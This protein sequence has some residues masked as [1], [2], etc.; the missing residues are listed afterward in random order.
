MGPTGESLRPVQMSPTRHRPQS[1]VGGGLVQGLG[2]EF[3]KLGEKLGE[4]LG[5]KVFGGRREMAASI[6]GIDHAGRLDQDNVGFPLSERAVLDTAGDDE[7]LSWS[8][9]HVPVAHLDGQLA[10]RNEKELIR[11]LMGVPHE[12]A[13]KLDHLNLVVVQ[14]GN[15]LGRPLLGEQ[16]K[17]FGNVNGD[18]FHS[19]SIA[20]PGQSRSR[21]M[22]RSTK[23]SPGR[24]K[25]LAL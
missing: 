12:L 21:I 13:L 11:V 20:E 3:E 23:P 6:T 15:H 25:G 19:P 22:W 5:E 24:P 4:E 16:G 10:A 17:P 1:A 14:P 7:E 2:R 9:G 8:E 18:M